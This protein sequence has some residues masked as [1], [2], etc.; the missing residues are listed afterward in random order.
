MEEDLERVREIDETLIVRSED[1]SLSYF[2]RFKMK[3]KYVMEKQVGLWKAI[4][5][6][7]YI[8]SDALLLTLVECLNSTN[9]KLN[10]VAAS[11]ST[12][13]IIPLSIRQARAGWSVRKYVRS[14]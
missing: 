1:D 6:K 9:G 5:S 10:R 13:I 12:P 14:E 8:C 3:A 2:I 7:Q 4:M 11:C